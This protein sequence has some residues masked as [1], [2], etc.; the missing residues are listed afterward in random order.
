MEAENDRNYVRS[1]GGRQFPFACPRCQLSWA[2]G[3]EEIKRIS[4]NQSLHCMDCGNDFDFFDALSNFLSPENRFLQYQIRSNH[5]VLGTT[6]I[7]VGQEYRVDLHGEFSRIHKVFLTP[8]TTTPFWCE[9][10]IAGNSGFLVISSR[11]EGTHA[12]SPV[13]VSYLVYGNKQ[14]F[15]TPPWRELLS[16]AKGHEISGDYRVAIVE[17]ATCFEV[18]LVQYLK[19][20]LMKTFDEKVVNSLLKKH[21]RIEDRVSLT[22]ELATGSTLEEM[23]TKAS[24]LILFESWRDHVQK[25]RNKIVHTDEGASLEDAKLAFEAVFKIIVYLQP[26]ALN[27]LACTFTCSR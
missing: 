3:K 18:F 16:D 22:F 23:L 17:F 10:I 6:K 9:P 20:R 26:E 4:E 27:Y 24:R 1:Y 12:P 15:E 14:G 7:L 21:Q 8:N 19:P 11:T 5:A 13:E 2:L 25:K